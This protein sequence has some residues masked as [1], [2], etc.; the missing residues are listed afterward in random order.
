MSA[1][2]AHV[3]VV[4]NNGKVE[5]EIHCGKRPGYYDTFIDLYRMGYKNDVYT[6]YRVEDGERYFVESYNY[7]DR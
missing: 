5:K 7:N 3:I 2:T 1:P 4:E 6:L